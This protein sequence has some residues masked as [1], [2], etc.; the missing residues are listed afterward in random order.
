MTVDYLNWAEFND[1]GPVVVVESPRTGIEVRELAVGETIRIATFGDDPVML[2]R[3]SAEH[4]NVWSEG[5]RGWGEVI[6][7]LPSGRYRRLRLFSREESIEPE[8]WHELIRARHR[9]AGD[10]A[11]GKGTPLSR[12]AGRGP[13]HLRDRNGAKG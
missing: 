7:R 1:R 3:V 10:A 9:A 12:P 5:E 4:Y 6:K 8:A 2:R 13:R 11:V